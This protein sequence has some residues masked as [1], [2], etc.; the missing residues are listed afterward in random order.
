M[1]PI[2]S[3]ASDTREALR[4]A[5]ASLEVPPLDLPR[6]HRRAPAYLALI[7][8][9]G[10][11]AGAVAYVRTSDGSTSVNP[12]DPGGSPRPAAD[13]TRPSESARSNSSPAQ[14]D[15]ISWR[16]ART[17][18]GST[19]VVI[20]FHGSAPYNSEDPCTSDYQAVVVTESTTSVE[21]RIDRT[22][23]PYP[24]PCRLV[25]ARRRVEGEL[26]SPLADRELIVAGESR[27]VFN[28]AELAH[29]ISLPDEWVMADEGP[30]YASAGLSAYWSQTWG[31]PRA[32]LNDARC[33][34]S[35][36]GITLVQGPRGL[37]KDSPV[38]DAEPSARYMVANAEAPFRVHHDTGQPF[39]T[40]S[41]GDR[42]FL[43]T[44][45]PQCLGDEVASV[46][47]MLRL[48]RSLQLPHG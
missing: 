11:T 16:G 32:T 45:V 13:I 44:S 36:A 41:V 20:A 7:C 23:P 34:A 21:I 8:A 10:A 33:V 30:E 26:E 43:V 29:P 9:A 38:P 2:D 17:V 3:R 25:A 22:A 48:A 12:S 15:D 35:A 27:D 4:A 1:K 47:S 46:D 42:E 37:L 39:L 24:G 40:W 18:R 5:I 19:A 14:I 6:G 28:G 31:P